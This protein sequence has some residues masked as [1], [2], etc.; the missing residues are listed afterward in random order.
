M[1]VQTNEAV[2]RLELQRRMLREK[3]QVNDNMIRDIDEH[4][5]Y[6]VQFKKEWLH[7]MRLMESE[8]RTVS[9][10]EATGRKR[11]EEH[12]RV[13]WDGIMYGFLQ[14]LRRERNA[15]RTDE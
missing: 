5:V 14:P 6:V 3:M 2:I 12:A 10:E 13:K 8:R 15:S 1:L 11:L 9:T 7:H 4:L